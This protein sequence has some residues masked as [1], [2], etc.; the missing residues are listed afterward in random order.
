M[1]PRKKRWIDGVEAEARKNWLMAAQDRSRWRHL[2]E[3]AKAH[4]RAVEPM[5]MIVTIII[6]IIVVVV[7]II[8]SSSSSSSS[9]IL[10]PLLSY[11]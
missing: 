9:S 3:Q 10:N 7:I 2:L 4:F 6:I 1:D 8:S 11:Y 5:T